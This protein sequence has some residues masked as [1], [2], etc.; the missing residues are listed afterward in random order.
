L[1]GKIFFDPCADI[2]RWID[3]TYSDGRYKFEL[4]EVKLALGETHGASTSTWPSR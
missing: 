4:G 3:E 2:T 1:T